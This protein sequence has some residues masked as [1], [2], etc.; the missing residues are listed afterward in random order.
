MD[1][2]ERNDKF[3]PV[4][5]IS[6]DGDVVLVVGPRN[7]RLRIQ[8][9]VLR[10]ASKVFGAI[11]GPTWSEG[12]GLVLSGTYV[13]R[14]LHELHHDKPKAADIYT[15]EILGSELC[16]TDCLCSSML[17]IANIHKSNVSWLELPGNIAYIEHGQSTY[18]FSVDINV[19]VTISSAL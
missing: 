12:Q 11:S 6:P 17:T 1:I 7:V 15:K 18:E 5:D 3:D 2:V 13:C 9:Q 14:R 19:A 16:Y 4:L 10:C 8:F